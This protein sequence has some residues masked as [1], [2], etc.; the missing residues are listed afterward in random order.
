MNWDDRQSLTFCRHGLWPESPQRSD[1]RD[2]R[3]SHPKAEE[4]EHPSPKRVLTRA[5]CTRP[6]GWSQPADWCSTLSRRL[7]HTASTWFLGRYDGVCQIAREW[8]CRPSRSSANL[9]YSWAIRSGEDGP[10]ARNH[11]ANAVHIVAIA[12]PASRGRPVAMSP[13]WA[14]AAISSSRMC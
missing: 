1:L 8:L 11:W 3:V 13:S 10:S 4:T 7:R 6:L 14:A 5:G 9:A 2:T 12:R